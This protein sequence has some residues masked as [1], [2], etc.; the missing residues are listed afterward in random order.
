MNKGF[1]LIELL[2]VVSIIALLVSILLPALGQARS[3]AK[4]AV[5]LSQMKQAGN[6][7]AVYEA[8]SD[9]Y[10]VTFYYP[11]T[12]HVGCGYEIT[13]WSAFIWNGYVPDSQI[14]HCPGFNKES[15]YPIWTKQDMQEG[16]VSV[17][18]TGQFGTNTGPLTPG[19]YGNHWAGSVGTFTAQYQGNNI[20]SYPNYI[21]TDPDRAFRPFK[22]NSFV[23]RRSEEIIVVDT[24]WSWDAWTIHYRWEDWKEKVDKPYGDLPD[25]T[26]HNLA[27]MY[28]WGSGRTAGFAPRHGYASN[29]LF[30]DG[31]ADTV[32]GELLWNA[33]WITAMSK[34]GA[35]SGNHLNE[36][37]NNPLDGY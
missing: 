18:H 16:V 13:Y 7:F 36:N 28:E 20:L 30:F 34:S 1:T 19:P 23:K 24:A 3:Q 10:I 15:V 21:H 32:D 8:D 35:L 22:A 5:C 12:N 25:A 6:A 14:I 11:D 2:V 33:E 27:H 9:G 26:E 37:G 29:C 17:I 31:H 4:K